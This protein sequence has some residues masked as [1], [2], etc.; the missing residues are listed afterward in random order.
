MLH[1]FA[2]RGVLTTLAIVVCLLAPRPSSL[3][4]LDAALTE[5]TDRPFI[6][7]SSLTNAPMV[8]I[9]TLLYRGRAALDRALE[10]RDQLR[11]GPSDPTAL[12]ELFDLLEL[13]RAD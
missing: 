5:L 7:A 10:L 13:A 12:D 1:A 9:E 11:R 4:L 6:P 8:P 3:N 2:S